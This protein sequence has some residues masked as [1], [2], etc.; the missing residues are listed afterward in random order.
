MTVGE[1]SNFQTKNCG[2]LQMSYFSERYDQI[3][4]P[5]LG[6]DQPGLRR[7]QLGAI[8]AISAHFTKEKDT[9]KIDSAITVMPTGSGKT[10]VISM[11]PF[12]L[13]AT[14]VLIVTPSRLVRQQISE[15][16][17]KLIVLK[18]IEVVSKDLETPTV[19]TQVT[20]VSNIQDWD[21]LRAADIVVS[22]PNCV[23]PAYEDIVDPPG[24]LFDVVV[25]DEAHHA[26]AKTWTA[27]LDAFPNSKKLLFTATPF[28]EDKKEIKGFVTYEFSIREAYNDRIFGSI[29]FIPVDFQAGITP[30]VAIALRTQE[31]LRQ[32]RDAG[33]DHYIFARTKTKKHARELVDI[34][35]NVTELNLRLLHSGHSNRY[36]KRTITQLK[37]KTLDGIIA[38]D[39]LGEGFDFPNLK[40]AA[41]HSPHKSLPV[42]LQFIGRFARTNTENIG[43]AKFLA[44]PQQIE[45]EAK[46]LYQRGSSWQEII[47]NLYQSRIEKEINI[48]QGL[49]SFQIRRI[50]ENESETELREISRYSLSP[51][52]H[53]KIFRTVDGVDLAREMA[54]PR[55]EI[56]R[57]DLSDE[58]DATLLLT[59]DISIPKW[60]NSGQFARVEYDLFIIYFDEESSLL[61]INTSRKTDSVYDQIVSQLAIG[62]YFPLPLY[63]IN[64][65]IS[66]LQN[67]TFFSIGMRNRTINS[68]TESYRIVAGS[69]AQRTIS[70]ADGRLYSQGHV[71]GRGEDENQKNM[72]LGFSGSSKVWSNKYSSIPEIID[73]CKELAIIIDSDLVV[74]TGSEL[75]S[76]P[77]GQEIR[78][79][80]L[81]VI[82]ADWEREVYLHPPFIS[83]WPINQPFIRTCQLLDIDISIDRGEVTEEKYRFIISD[84]SL[85]WKADYSPMNFPFFREVAGN[86]AVNV[87]V[88]NEEI[89]LIAFINQNPIQFFTSN[90]TLLTGGEIYP[91][92]QIEK[93][94]DVDRI[95]P[96]DWEAGNVNIKREFQIEGQEDGELSIHEYMQGWADQ[97][98]D[99]IIF[100]DHG[101]GEIADLVTFRIDDQSLYISLLHVKAMKLNNHAPGSRVDEFDEL[102]MQAVSS[103]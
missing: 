56:V 3:R 76:L 48:R 88:G 12:V 99:Q 67:P 10:A 47:P 101:K 69:Q 9:S 33:L 32:D 43:T 60:A 34:Y 27:I 26:P 21:A 79:L 5:I 89:S 7:A 40:I 37:N 18:Q 77:V 44:I 61:F 93:P 65:V 84:D 2:K 78:V 25:V 49:A 55:L 42:T 50:L 19:A 82:G 8:H 63:E 102:S 85:E 62:R 51:Y 86:P 96:F 75:D 39:M 58:L 71:F 29:E 1:N 53:V 20:K 57:Q 80:P 13:Q 87:I 66:K 46:K 103:P 94:F 64:R 4:Y 17:S 90:F 95:I 15:E 92:E 72:T 81:D 70:A 30:D 38:V 35:R 31:I 16:I 100:Y 68:Q 59:K 28:R 14:R 52:H 83:Y 22:T 11:A 54:L 36:A 98:G 45:V 97:N 73:W 74:V 91:Y 24:D 23:S 6:P 41:I